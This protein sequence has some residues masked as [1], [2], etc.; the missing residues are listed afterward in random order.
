MSASPLARPCAR[1]RPPFAAAALA[2]AFALCAASVAAGQPP[3]V[4]TLDEAVSAALA[5]HASIAAARLDVTAAE[6]LTREASRRPPLTFSAQAENFGGTGAGNSLETTAELGWKLELGGDRAARRAAAIAGGDVARATL[7]ERARGLRAEVTSDFARAWAAQE[8]W[9]ALAEA[10]ADA[11]ASVEVARE[12]LRAGAAPSLE[13]AR[14]E[15]EAA[16]ARA[17][18]AR[19]GAA[20]ESARRALAARWRDEVPA[21]D[22][23]ALASPETADTP[24]ADVPATHPVLA[25]AEAAQRAAEAD[26][27]SAR[28]RRMPD[29][30]RGVGARRFREDGATGLVAG[31]SLPFGEVGAGE[32]AAAR[33][34]ATRA[35]LERDAAARTLRTEAGNAAANLQGALAAWRELSRIAAPRAEEALE[36]LRSGYRAGRFGYVDLAE[37]RRAALESRIAVIE[38]A[39]DVWRAHA[40][41]ERLTGSAPPDGAMEDSR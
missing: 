29:L 27:R 26:A 19:A 15:S 13:V 1:P 28:A 23:L 9:L 32:A 17:E 12:R 35:A 41:L 11:A 39:A 22:S 21:F 10:A 7:A 25:S 33:A 34:R 20:L 18:L 38:A 24:P 14:S 16:R 36:L 40:E 4:L 2:C 31:L 30:D 37:A 3:R 5:R 6:A 8:R